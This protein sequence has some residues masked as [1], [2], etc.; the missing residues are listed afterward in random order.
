M[1]LTKKQIMEMNKKWRN[2]RLD[3]ATRG[4]D[5]YFVIDQLVNSMEFYS[6][7]R[8]WL[9]HMGKETEYS[10]QQ[11]KKVYKAYY[12]L[13]PQKRFNM[14]FNWEKWLGKFGIKESVI[15][16]GPDAD[17]YKAFTKVK[18]DI[19]NILKKYEKKSDTNVGFYTFM[20]ELKEMIKKMGYAGSWRL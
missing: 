20:S 3:E 4:S 2:F 14:S 8:S 11:L 1:T 6:T 13:S 10:S 16:E 9:K 19:Y 15:N 5:L 12:K 17:L 7:E 18:K